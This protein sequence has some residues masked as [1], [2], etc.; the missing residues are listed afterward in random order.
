M[1][2]GARRCGVRAEGK[3]RADLLSASQKL[4]QDTV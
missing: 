2:L 1:D 3:G 4:F